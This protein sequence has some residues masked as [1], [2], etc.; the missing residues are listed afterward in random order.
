MTQNHFYRYLYRLAVVAA[1][2]Y[3]FFAAALRAQ[4]PVSN[5]PPQY[6]PYNGVFLAGGDGLKAPL[7][8]HDSVLLAD[9]AWTLYCW[10]RAD[11]P[12]QNSTLLAGLWRRCRGISAV[13]RRGCAFRFFVDGQRQ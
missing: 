5:D 6:G 9:S 4:I 2:A 12:L 10:V 11:E 13:P 3:V 8:E 7:A 1:L